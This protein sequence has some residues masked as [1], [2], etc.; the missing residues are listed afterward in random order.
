[1]GATEIERTPAIAA[2]SDVKVRDF[3]QIFRRRRYLVDPRYQMRSGLLVGTVAFT[4]L[5]LL[6][7]SLYLATR[8]PASVLATLGPSAG[9]VLPAQDRAQVLLA[10]FGSVVF[11]VGVVLVGVLESH[12]TAGAAYRIG[13]GLERLRRGESS[14]EVRLRRDDHL[15]ELAQAVNGLAATMREREIREIERLEALVLRVENF[16]ADRAVEILVSDLRVATA[17]RRRALD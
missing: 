12:R 14:V 9:G 4:L 3:D 11:L 1:M 10:V 8:A 2:G 6:N 16:P 17:T 13:R 5:V 15:Q 7:F